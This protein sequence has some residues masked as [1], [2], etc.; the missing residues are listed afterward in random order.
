M[1][2]GLISVALKSACRD[3]RNSAIAAKMTVGLNMRHYRVVGLDAYGL[4]RLKGD[5]SFAP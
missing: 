3:H 1:V 2:L 4:S 5:R